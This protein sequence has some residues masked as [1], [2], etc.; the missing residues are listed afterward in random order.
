MA[1]QQSID[2]LVGLA[3]AMLGVAPGTDWLN[4]RA[5]QLDGGATLA[6]IANEIQSSSAFEDKYPAFLTNE[7]FA[8]DFLEALLGDHVDDAV[9]MAAVDFVAGQL[10]GASRGELALALVDALTIIGGEGGS[11]ADM[12]FRTLHSG[13]FGK[14]AAAFHN[15]VMVAKHYT[16]EARKA[17]PSS[18]VLETVTDAAES[19][20]AAINAIDNPPVAPPSMDGETFVLTGLRDNLVGTAQDDTFIAEPTLNPS[21][22]NSVIPL[23]SY[24]AIDGGDGIDTLEVYGFAQ[25]DIRTDQVENVE[26]VLL[27]AQT[28]IDADM[29][30]WEGLESV[31]A[32]R[33]NG[34]VDITVDGAMVVFGEAIGSYRDSN[35]VLMGY[36]ATIDGAG[37]ELKIGAARL[38]MV[39]IVTRGHTTSV[40]ATGGSVTIDSNGRGGLSDSLTSVSAS[41][42]VSLNVSSDALETLSLSTS[43]GSATL[44]YEG[45]TEL[46]VVVPAGG[47]GF[48]GRY[49]WDANPNTRATNER[50]TLRLHDTN[51]NDDS[52]LE[53]LNIEVGASSRFALDSHVTHL[54]V[55]GSGSLTVETAVDEAGKF[56]RAETT[57]S[58]GM[59]N[60]ERTL[61]DEGGEDTDTIKFTPAGDG[62]SESATGTLE[63][64]T[65]TGEAGLSINVAGGQARVAGG[66]TRVLP[67]DSEAMRNTSTHSKDLKS[68]DA[69]ES[70]GKNDFTVRATEKLASVHGGSGD[71]T[72]RITQGT[73]APTGLTVELGDGDDKL[74][75]DGVNANPFSGAA[76][77]VFD[78]GA[79]DNT[80]HLTVGEK[81][82]EHAYTDSE[83]EKQSFYANFK[84]LDVGAGSGEYDF[85]MLGT[86]YLQ[87]TKGTSADGV[88]VKNVAPGTAILA[89]G[90]SSAGSSATKAM[91]KY[92]LA[93]QEVG[94]F[95]FGGGDTLNV[96][97]HAVGRFSDKGDN[98]DTPR[99]DADVNDASNV[100]MELKVGD[101]QGLIFD[102]SARAGGT[103]IASD[104][105]NIIHAD[106]KGVTSV[107]ITG[108]AK[109]ELKVKDLDDGATDAPEDGLQLGLMDVGYVDARANTAG[110]TVIVGNAAGRDI[111]NLS[112]KWV[113]VLGSD[114]ADTLRGSTV[115]SVGNQ[116]VG[117][118]GND[119][120]HGG[121]AVDYLVGGAGADTLRGFGGADNYDYSEVSDSRATFVGSAVL[122]VDTI[123]GFVSGTD[124][125]RLSDDLL[126]EV[127]ERVKGNAEF[128]SPAA[129]TDGRTYAIDST[130]IDSS[131]VSTA[132]S[133][134]ALIG[135]GDGFFVFR[136]SGAVLGEKHFIAVVNEQY[137]MDD[138]TTVGAVGS[139][140]A[141]AGPDGEFNADD[142]EHYRTWVLFDINGDGDF[143]AGSDLVIQLVGTDQTATLS[144][145]GH[146]GIDEAASF[147]N[148]ASIG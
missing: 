95:V 73:L 1:T 6:D 71:D 22:G 58:N 122:G 114:A 120:L 63:M 20:T 70:S 27:N 106:A 9:M 132:D 13:N 86:E 48:G 111:Q 96:N 115:A 31:N 93:T 35:N 5:K 15:K 148:I 44:N 80:L 142:T 45:L 3:V 25:L 105:T 113:T 66:Q 46:D 126:G 59:T 39:D 19:V 40:D 101:I 97:L 135:D 91:I 121:G 18:S 143:D 17:E 131:T 69:S 82:T 139:G 119:T 76:V 79:G 127:N 52:A 50:G 118:G 87:I 64:I 104:Y 7:R 146:F 108:D 88:T 43:F 28:F 138:M 14:A 54:N 62:T 99:Y 107:R 56:I 10:A 129:R 72:V 75:V 140:N 49:D 141:T 110:V 74:R 11:E 29:S 84:T 133:L 32:D 144:D 57:T 98:P 125:I 2:H 42:F 61:V 137:W 145:N 12:A 78:G 92:Q 123:I 36:S 8:K 30:E 41:R 51:A 33:F 103:A 26:H 83:G 67:T 16:E 147:G 65:V 136:A 100:T 34:N 112:G 102:S 130:D 38:A 23:Q 47:F 53:T 89:T 124:H 134:R 21:T 116:L 90:S 4:A 68:I 117:N 77:S 81:S 109:A 55:S 128:I 37:G 85:A 24:D 60:T 94:S